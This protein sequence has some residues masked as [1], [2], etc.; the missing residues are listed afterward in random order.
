MLSFDYFYC[1]FIYFNLFSCRKTN[2]KEKIIKLRYSDI[3]FF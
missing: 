3:Q 2:E 1:F